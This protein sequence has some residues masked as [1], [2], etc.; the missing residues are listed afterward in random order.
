MFRPSYF[1]PSGPVVPQAVINSTATS[2]LSLQYSVIQVLEK[3]LGILVPVK[4]LERLSKVDSIASKKELLELLKK[5]ESVEVLGEGTD[6]LAFRW[7]KKYPFMNK[8]EFMEWIKENR[9]IVILNDVEKQSY[10][11]LK[12][13]ILKLHA[14][15]KVLLF[16]PPIKLYNQG[17]SLPEDTVVLYNDK[18]SESQVSEAVKQA[19]RDTF[20]EDLHIQDARNA[21]IKAKIPLA[22]TKFENKPYIFVKRIKEKNKKR[23]EYHHKP[24]ELLDSIELPE[25]FTLFEVDHSKQDE[26]S[27]TPSSTGAETSEGKSI[28]ISK[29]KQTP[30]HIVDAIQRLS[31]TF[32]SDEVIVVLDCIAQ[33]GPT[34][35]SKLADDL[36]LSPEQ[37]R[38][39]LFTLQREHLM[40]H[41]EVKEDAT[42][43]RSGLWYIEF[44][45]FV[46]IVNYRI[47]RINANINEAIHKNET[48]PER[49]PNCKQ[50]FNASETMTILLT[51]TCPYPNCGKI[52][53]MGNVVDLEKNKKL[54]N[55]V[56]MELVPLKTIFAP[57]NNSSAPVHSSFNH[58]NFDGN[59][60]N[61]SGHVNGNGTSSDAATNSGST[62]GGRKLP[63][64]QKKRKPNPPGT[65]TTTTTTTSSTTKT[66]SFGPV[67]SSVNNNSV[68]NAP[69]RNPFMKGDSNAKDGKV[70]NGVGSSTG[71][72]GGLILTR[73]VT[74]DLVI[75]TSESNPGPIYFQKDGH[76]LLPLL[77]K[78]LRNLK[79]NPSIIQAH[80][81]LC[82]VGELKLYYSQVFDFT[83][84][85][86]S[87]YIAQTRNYTIDDI[88]SCLQIMTRGMP[89]PELE[90]I[91]RISTDNYFKASISLRNGRYCVES[92][93][94]DVIMKLS[95]FSSFPKPIKEGN[96]LSMMDITYSFEIEST[97]CEG[98][99][100]FGHQ[101]KIPI[102]D[103]F[104]Y[105]NDTSA[106]TVKID[107]RY[108]ET[109]DYQKDAAERMFWN[110]EVHS[111]LL[112]LPCGAGKTYCGVNITSKM[113]KNAVIFCTSTLA[114]NQWKE[115]YKKWSNIDP[116][117]ISKF[118][119]DSKSEWDFNAAIII[120]TYAM[121]S[122]TTQKSGHSLNMINKCKERTWGLMILDEVH[123]APAEMFR[124][125]TT[126]FKA[127]VKLGLTATMI[128]EDGL[129]EDLP[130]LVGPKLF[131][132]DLLS[133]R[134]N[135]YIATIHCTEIKVPMTQK[136]KSV[137][138]YSEAEKR[139][140]LF[141]TNPNKV[142]VVNQ[143]IK[144]HFAKGHKI[145][146]F[147]DDLF[148]LAWFSK[149]LNKEYI[150]GKTPNDA[151]EHIL[152]A[153][154]KSKGGDFVL[155]SKVGDISIDLPEAN[156]LI[157]IGIVDGSR[158]QEAQRVGRIQ[159][160]VIH[161]ETFFYS[162]ISDG[163]S[164]VEYSQKRRLFMEEH[165]YKYE[166]KPF[167]KFIPL[168][169]QVE[170]VPFQQELLSAI[171]TTL[172]NRTKGGEDGYSSVT[173]A[174]KSK[175]KK[176]GSARERLQKTMKK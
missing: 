13:D 52:F 98:V 43:K 23:K 27:S 12:E 151:R 21:L 111:G 5:N 54:Q 137:H 10:P 40:H 84:T 29:G 47:M 32:Y 6:N 24:S 143:L 118:T 15:K 150:D 123:L 56:N 70:E 165:G 132:V 169:Q 75:E 126:E 152:D 138:S 36:C 64:S 88:I 46:D 114:V 95:L 167:D 176:D 30:Q 4:E 63:S 82:L 3:H 136:F 74:T 7:K 124:K 41:L 25:E 17:V 9:S 147:S 38:S 85:P 145:L 93:D 92:L 172:Q 133:L 161:T 174:D 99:R 45:E 91:R 157:Q 164:E 60:H 142:L 103:R 149:V 53:D 153:F 26:T 116:K 119:S 170:N 109:R 78:S 1:R 155:L 55:L 49:C 66:T 154:R 35:D 120:T 108:P 51:L 110:N 171:D 105:M 34:K 79:W 59:S 117:Q 50:A 39:A 162:L 62:S 100:R 77:Q 135:K 146:V 112:I 67:S 87:L 101:S 160:S 28:A 83:I 134:A 89:K 125:V 144:K 168:D 48:I 173:V 113:K 16:L 90:R 131:E 130:F 61:S 148:G 22:D 11:R 102:I 42:K 159:R 121:F 81:L 33:L 163:T 18:P 141:I 19:W 80:K 69:L 44:N 115:Q 20:V 128:R 140:L 106:M 73:P 107:L 175:N 96:T 97:E 72:D 122:V 65:A 94:K 31:R 129:I 14:E 156:V 68:K 158:M 127:H 166:D 71:A 76:Y 37:V 58:G 86:L 104:T 57:L 8:D 2:V 139:K